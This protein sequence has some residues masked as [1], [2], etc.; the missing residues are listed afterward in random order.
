MGC[1]VPLGDE[2]HTDIPQ[3]LK[4]HLR[5]TVPLSGL[6]I[7]KRN[8][9]KRN[10]KEKER[11]RNEEGENTRSRKKRLINTVLRSLRSRIDGFGKLWLR[12]R[13]VCSVLWR[14]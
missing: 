1:S 4:L 13:V 8:K 3:K 14:G 10:C 9:R 2:L 12:R 11:V 6:K 7:P 5:D